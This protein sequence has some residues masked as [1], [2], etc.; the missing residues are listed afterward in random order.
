MFGGGF[1]FGGM[2]GMPGFGMAGEPSGPVNNTRY[3][4]VLGLGT[5]A[6]DSE[7]KKAFRKLAARMHPDKGA[8]ARFSC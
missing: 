5:D 1:P 4:E 8:P 2:G 3:Y 6:S 7:I